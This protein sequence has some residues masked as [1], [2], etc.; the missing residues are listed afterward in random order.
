MIRRSSV[1]AKHAVTVDGASREHAR[2]GAAVGD[3]TTTDRSR[4]SAATLDREKL[5][6]RHPRL[7]EVS[8]HIGRRDIDLDMHFP[9]VRY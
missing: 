2:L 4:C 1:H 9:N 5:A 7:I 8:A 3:L 6:N